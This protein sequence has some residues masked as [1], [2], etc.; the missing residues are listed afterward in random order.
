MERNRISARQLADSLLIKVKT[1]YQYTYDGRADKLLPPI[2]RTPSGKL[3]F[4]EDEVIK[5]HDSHS[6]NPVV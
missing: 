3:Y 6:S 5:W 1:L 4:Y 2:H